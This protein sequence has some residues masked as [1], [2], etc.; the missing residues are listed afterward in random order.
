MK[1][2]YSAPCMDVL[3]VLERASL[4]AG[5]NVEYG[6]SNSQEDAPKQAESKSVFDFDDDDISEA[7]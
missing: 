2:N 6:G 3:R 4:L 7:K 5:T 1:K